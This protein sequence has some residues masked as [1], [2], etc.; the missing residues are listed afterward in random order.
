MPA[1]VC[2]GETTGNSGRRWGC[3]PH[4]LAGKVWERAEE[5]IRCGTAEGPHDIATLFLVH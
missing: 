2:I 4:N 5:R 3:G 1:K